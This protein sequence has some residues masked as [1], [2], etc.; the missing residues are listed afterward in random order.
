MHTSPKILDKVKRMVDDYYALAYVPVAE[1]P[2]EYLETREHL[3]RPP[4]GAKWKAAKRG[5]T[6]GGPWMTAWFRGRFKPSAKLAGQPLFLRANTGGHESLVWLNGQPVGEIGWNAAICGHY[7]VPV[8]LISGDQT[9]CAEAVDLLREIE[10]AVV[11]QA[12][13]RMAAEC[14]P[15]QVARQKI[16]EAARQ[17]VERL[18]QGQTPA[19]LRLDLPVIVTVELVQS[20][21]ADRAAIFPGARRLEGKRVEFTAED[22]PTAYRGFRAVVALARD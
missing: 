3:R 11:K 17:A 9:A 20:Q 14:L 13:G 19:P 22:A 18:C 2:I 16:A 4:A 21:M 1:L 8:I 15:P 12:S 7:G 5:M 10:T 6:W